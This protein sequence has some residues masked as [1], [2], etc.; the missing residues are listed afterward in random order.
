MDGP[1]EGETAGMALAVRGRGFMVGGVERVAARPTGSGSYLVLVRPRGFLA[2]VG[3]R[4]VVAGGAGGAYALLNQGMSMP[5]T[6][7]TASG[8]TIRTQAMVDSGSTISSVDQSLMASSGAVPTGTQ[9]IADVSGTLSVP[10]YSVRMQTASGYD[11]TGSYLTVLADDLPPPQQALVGRDILRYYQLWYDGSGS[12][13]LL[14]Q[15][16][17]QQPTTPYAAI[18]G[19]AL[20]AAVAGVALGLSGRMGRSA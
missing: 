19:G 20:V 12:W 15:G 11:L 1:A 18:A 5:V 16:A 13:A 8:K 17:P 14:G 3:T 4:F 9:Q 6:I 2:T 7:T 10:T